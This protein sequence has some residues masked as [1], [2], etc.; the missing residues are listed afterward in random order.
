MVIFEDLK[1]H[2][3]EFE[4]CQQNPQTK[5]VPLLFFFRKISEKM[6]PWHSNPEIANAG[7][8]QTTSTSSPSMSASPRIFISFAKISNNKLFR[9]ST[10]TLLAPLHNFLFRRTW[11][12]MKLTKLILAEPTTDSVSAWDKVISSCRITLF[13]NIPWNSK[14]WLKSSEMT[15]LTH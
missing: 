12:L 6:K 11:R 10:R 4:R 13:R 2:I 15:C 9:N 1:N 3:A 8:P 7:A 14:T 5:S